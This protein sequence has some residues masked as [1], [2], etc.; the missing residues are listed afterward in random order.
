MS[1]TKQI[2][3]TPKLTEQ[4][5]TDQWVAQVRNEYRECLNIVKYNAERVTI[6]EPQ[7]NI[8]KEIVAESTR[9]IRGQVFKM[10]IL[11]S[12]ADE[13]NFIIPHSTGIILY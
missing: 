3:N 2:S 9:I 13:E 12:I 4:V 7:V 10:K 11:Q 1:L 5:K 6:D 8:P